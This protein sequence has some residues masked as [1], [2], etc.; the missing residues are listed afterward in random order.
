MGDLYRAVASYV[1]KVELDEF[2]TSNQ[3]LAG[4]V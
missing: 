4:L 1:L 3:K 2:P